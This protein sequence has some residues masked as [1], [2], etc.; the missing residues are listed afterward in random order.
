[1]HV[2]EGARMVPF[3]GYSMPVQYEGIIAEHLHTRE[4]A[5]AFDVSHMGQAVLVG[6]DHA[7]TATAL[8][9]LIPA[10][11]LGLAPGR[12][13]YSQFTNDAGGIL[14]DLMVFRPS[15]PNFDGR[16]GLVVNAARKHA[17]Y[18]HLAA[19]LPPSVT[20]VPIA[21]RALIAL[22]GPKSVAVMERLGAR[23]ADWPF[24]SG[25]PVVLADL[26][27]DVTGPATP[28][29]TASRFPFTTATRRICG[30]P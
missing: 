20:L 12:Q 24:M 15:G 4:A 14:D 3:A 30:K 5:G 16:L 10:D 11:I 9:A 28:A 25:G 27:C 21:D 17:D 18:D 19:K 13:R 26:E 2:A 6:P 22:Q 8:E 29:R 1:M 23:V 7:T